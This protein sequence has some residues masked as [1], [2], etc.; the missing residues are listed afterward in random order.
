[1]PK[2]IPQYAKSTDPE[3]IATIEANK[4]RLREF[5]ELARAFQE[6]HAVDNDPEDEGDTFVW[7]HGDDRGLAGVISRGKPEDGQ[8]KPHGSRP[9]VWEPYKNNPL[10][11]EF[12]SIRC[13]GEIPKGLSEFYV[14]GFDRRHGSTIMHTPQTFVHDG[15]AYM[16]LGGAPLADQTAGWGDGEFDETVWTEMLGS[17]FHAALDAYNEAREEATR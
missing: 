6:R 9:N 4:A 17:E 5:G 14:T 7:S 16:G 3:V 12:N 1:M 13:K 8:W 15:V 11:R 2:Y 10:R